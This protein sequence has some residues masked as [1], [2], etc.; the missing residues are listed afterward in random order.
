MRC[1]RK[2]KGRRLWNRTFLDSNCSSVT[3]GLC[4]TRQVL[5]LSELPFLHTAQ[6]RCTPRAFTVPSSRHCP[7]R[8]AAPNCIWLG[9]LCEWIALAR[10]IVNVCAIP[11]PEHWVPVWHTLGL[12]PHLA[13][14]VTIFNLDSGFSISLGGQSIA[15]G[16]SHSRPQHPPSM[17]DSHLPWICPCATRPPDVVLAYNPVTT[18]LLLTHK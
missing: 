15:L 17:Q 4:D 18:Q 14:W 12:S 5:N 10:P 1:G 16:A 9:R 6:R 8:N 11:K 3:Y 13:Q 7:D 2:H